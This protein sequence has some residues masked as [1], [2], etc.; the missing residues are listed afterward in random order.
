MSAGF[1]SIYNLVI[2][3]CQA[4][5]QKQLRKYDYF[6]F[7]ANEGAQSFRVEAAILWYYEY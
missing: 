2:V 3:R 5:I 7:A 6:M 4:S 1:G